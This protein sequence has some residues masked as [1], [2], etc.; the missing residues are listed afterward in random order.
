MP[1]NTPPRVIGPMGRRITYLAASPNGQHI[2]FKHIPQN[3]ATDDYH[4]VLYQPAD[5]TYVEVDEL[6][7]PPPVH[8]GYSGL[9]QRAY[10]S[11]L[12]DGQCLSIEIEPVGVDLVRYA[13]SANGLVEVFR[14]CLVGTY[15]TSGVSVQLV[16]SGKRAV[17]HVS[18]RDDKN[19]DWGGG[20]LPDY[21][22][23]YLLVDVASGATIENYSFI[24][25]SW[26]EDLISVPGFSNAGRIAKTP[27]PDWVGTR[28]AAETEALEKL[29]K[30]LSGDRNDHARRAGRTRLLTRIQVIDIAS[31]EPLLQLRDDDARSIAFRPFP[32]FHEF[33]P[34]ENYVL[35]TIAGGSFELWNVPAKT[36]WRPELAAHGGVHTAVF[37]P[38]GR[39]ALGTAGAGVI[40][41]DCT[42]G[43]AAGDQPW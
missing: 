43:I 9:K 18:D 1:N 37:L 36:S 40:I 27:V 15:G 22:Q 20:P 25:N 13:P 3:Y 6:P 35:S 17:V 33:S 31:G 4:D 12:D 34:D 19:A 21:P 30:A 16:D 23:T 8:Y 2:A 24:C 42:P 14:R 41:V 5:D 39:A 38:H 7:A 11:P 28:N 32:C 10:F 29:I 26:D